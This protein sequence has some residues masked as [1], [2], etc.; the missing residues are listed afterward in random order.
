[1]SSG[2]EPKSL[3]KRRISRG[4]AAAAVIV[5]LSCAAAGA[6]SLYYPAPQDVLASMWPL[7]T[8]VLAAVRSDSPA[9]ALP[10]IEQWDKASAQ[11]LPSLMLRAQWPD[12]LTRQRVDHL[13][14]RLA[15]LRGAIQDDRG[16]DVASLALEC[17]EAHRQ[18]AALF[19]EVPPAAVLA[20]HDHGGHAHAGVDSA[21]HHGA[22]H[23]G[24]EHGKREIGPEEPVP[25]VRV[26]VKPDLL[27]KGW[28]LRV[29]TEN[30][31]FAPE[32][33]S[34]DHVPGEG[35]AHLYVDG[36][37][38]TRLYSEWHFLGTLAPGTH[39]VRV[40]LNTNDHDDYVHNGEVIADEATVGVPLDPNDPLCRYPLA[41]ESGPALAKEEILF[42]RG[43]RTAKAATS[44]EEQ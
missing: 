34:G 9:E 29:A 31:R 13:R 39:V 16:D 19:E 38:V 43:E 3:W 37:K 40:T 6:L 41:L 42:G 26:E 20:A 24:H 33:A 22:A 32:R 10:A 11:L 17:F 18:C 21:A 44:A 28:N 12:D 2:P 4:W 1:M 14:E 7:R 36:K 30:F 5:V 27:N 23:A 8:K 35:H 25:S 15:A